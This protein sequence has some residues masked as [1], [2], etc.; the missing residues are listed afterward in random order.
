MQGKCDIFVLL[1]MVGFRFYLLLIDSLFD[2][3][4][5]VLMTKCEIHFSEGGSFN[6]ELNPLLRSAIEE[7]TRRGVPKST[8]QNFLKKMTETKDKTNI[9]RHLFEGRLYKKLYVI[10]SIYTDNLAHTKIQIATHYRKHLVDATNVKRLFNERG[11][12]N[13]IARDG[14]AIDNIEDECLNDA[15]ECGAEDVEVFNAAERQV[16]F[17]CSPTEFLRVR[18]KL[19]LAGHKIEHSECAFFPNTQ[20]V[21]LSE[22][23][24]ADYEKFKEKLNSIDGFDEIYDNLDDS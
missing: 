9:Q 23:E 4:R 17:F 15:V 11:I 5:V 2:C 6:P 16:S 21:R 7:A 13:V 22:S 20:L 18:H 19:A 8:I 12:F 24:L 3:Y 10:I 1:G 14:I